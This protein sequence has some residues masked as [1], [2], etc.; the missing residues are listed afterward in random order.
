VNVITRG[1]K[2][3]IKYYFYGGFHGKS[4]DGFQVFMGK[5]RENK[6]AP[7]ASSPLLLIAPT[8]A[9][10]LPAAAH[11]L[12]RWHPAALVISARKPRNRYTE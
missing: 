1:E 7:F 4:H 3:I 12:T 2:N 10:A 5:S 9:N 11:R 8:M 6:G